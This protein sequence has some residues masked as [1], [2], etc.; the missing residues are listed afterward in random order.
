MKLTFDDG[1]MILYFYAEERKGAKAAYKAIKAVYPYAE[2]HYTSILVDENA[3]WDEYQGMKRILE[4][5]LKS[6]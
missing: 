3:T 6:S 1:V 2:M 5:W 4:N